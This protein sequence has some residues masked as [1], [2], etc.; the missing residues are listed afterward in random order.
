MMS[1]EFCEQLANLFW[2]HP[3]LKNNSKDNRGG[4]R[5]NPVAKEFR[6]SIMDFRNYVT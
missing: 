3:I 6:S 2:K 4:A 5:A 1:L